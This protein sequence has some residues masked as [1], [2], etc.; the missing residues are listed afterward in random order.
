[1]NRK[2]IEL[3]IQ[4]MTRVKEY[5]KSTKRKFLDMSD[6]VIPSNFGPIPTT[7]EEVV[8]SCG[9][10]CCVSG[11]LAISP[12]FRA[13]GVFQGD[14][15]EAVAY[16]ETIHPET[17]LPNMLFGS[18]SLTLAYLFDLPVNIIEDLIY[19][20]NILINNDVDM[21]LKIMNTWI[22]EFDDLKYCHYHDYD[23]YFKYE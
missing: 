2:N 20:Q 6:F 23:Y 16:G 5:E 1:M 12:E 17:T 11:W 19:E 10:T 7:E 18:S 8:N 15:G 22:T 21:V 3:A 4:V 14:W 9:T 13:L